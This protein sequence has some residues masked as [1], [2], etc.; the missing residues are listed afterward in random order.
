M[1]KDLNCCV[2]GHIPIIEEHYDTLQVVCKNCGRKGRLFIGDYD[3]E[4]FMF[5]IYGKSA[6]QDWNRRTDK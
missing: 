1:I 6:I 4:V 2:C 3:D 5:S